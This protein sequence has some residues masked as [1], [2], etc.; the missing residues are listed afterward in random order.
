MVSTTYIQNTC[1]ST[2][3]CWGRWCANTSLSTTTATTS[4]NSTDIYTIW[5]N[6]AITAPPQR[7]QE[8]L[9]RIARVQ[10]ELEERYKQE[11]LEREEERRLSQERAELL[12]IQHLNEKQKRVYEENKCIPI[13]GQSGK[14]Y[15]IRRGRAKNIDVLKDDGTV[16]YR[17]CVHPQEQ[18]PD[19]DTMLAQK[20]L[21]SIANKYPTI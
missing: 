18:V 19:E 15:V 17:L 8:E 11:R 14:K 3:A 10:L 1:S 4:F 9:D 2:D 20:Y 6:S 21:I 13:D 12:L 5:V 16:E 7:S